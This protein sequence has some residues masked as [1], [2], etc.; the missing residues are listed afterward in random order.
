MADQA[1]VFAVGEFV[2]PH[3]HGLVLVADLAS[4]DLA[5]GYGPNWPLG[6]APRGI[7]FGEMEAAMPA[8]V[9][10]AKAI[11]APFFFGELLLKGLGTGEV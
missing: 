2:L 5:I 11:L 1:K 8:A 7:V 4:K 6:L 9:V 3:F 10:S